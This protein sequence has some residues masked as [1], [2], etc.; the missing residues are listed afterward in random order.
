MAI[1]RD[2]SVTARLMSACE[3]FTGLPAEAKNRW[4][5]IRLAERAGK[6]FGLGFTD[7]RLLTLYVGYTREADWLTG[8]RPLYTR[9]V[10]RTASDL[11]ISARQVNRSENRLEKL[12]L[13]LRDTRADGYRG[14]VREETEEGRVVYAV[15]LRP[16]AVA[17]E[18]MARSAEA[19]A[20]R[21]RAIDTARVAISRS[22][23][24]VAR[25]AAETLALRPAE[26]TTIE[27]LL[28]PLPTRTP[29]HRDLPRLVAAQSVLEEAATRLRAL[30]DRAS[31]AVV[32]TG[33]NP[34]MSEE[35]SDAVVERVPHRI[36]T[37]PLPESLCRAGKSPMRSPRPDPASALHALDPGDDPNALTGLDRLRTAHVVAAMP[38]DWHWRMKGRF[39]WRV[40]CGIA[41]S[42]LGALGV[43][44]HAWRR[45]TMVIGR[46]AASVALMA[47]EINRDHPTAPIRNIGGA[48][49]QFAE[50]ATTGN[51]RLDAT[52]I[53]ILARKNEG[54][55][56]G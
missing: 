2:A 17:W 54:V 5:L 12:G 32:D 55:A 49:F 4:S 52:I 9:P 36:N 8:G 38:E 25:L 10:W 16:L 34:S 48:I 56:A 21:E 45:L 3:A 43:G 51:L 28:H 27:A 14:T 13:I 33:D 6:H 39:E 19:V 40:F 42:R 31:G 30:L 24:L 35:E 41:E 47:L 26:A 23:R 37:K 11:G 7:L 44:L 20:N 50:I 18:A 22:L 15:D 1:A 53:G 29:R 46:R